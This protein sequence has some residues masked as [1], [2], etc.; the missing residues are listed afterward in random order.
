MA[1][2]TIRS[3]KLIEALPRN[4]YNVTKSAL[5]AGF[6]KS[7]AETQQKR[8]MRTALKVQAKEVLKDLENVDTP[9]STLKKTMAEMVGLS[10]EDVMNNIKELATQDRDYSTRLKVIKALAKELGV[11]LGEDEGANVTVPV[12]NVTVKERSTEPLTHEVEPQ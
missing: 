6:T 9:L 2:S 7:T 3:K 5:E 10:R 8:L 11:D 12:L 1:L 4:N